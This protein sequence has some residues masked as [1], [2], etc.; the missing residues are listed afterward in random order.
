MTIFEATD[1]CAR[2]LAKSLAC[3]SFL[4]VSAVATA[5]TSPIRRKSSIWR[6]RWTVCI[7]AFAPFMRKAL[8]WKA[9][10][11]LGRSGQA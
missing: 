3:A 5:D 7:R 4:L 2:R 8:F 9:A 11:R 6:T 10:S 1:S